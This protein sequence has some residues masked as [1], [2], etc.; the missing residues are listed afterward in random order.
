MLGNIHEQDI[1]TT[2]WIKDI[3]DNR[4]TITSDGPVKS[5]SGT[6]AVILQSN[7]QELCFQ[8]PINCYPTLLESYKAEL[9]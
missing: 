2:Y 7:T 5:G 9:T 8:G 3:N 1:D 6:F 4:V